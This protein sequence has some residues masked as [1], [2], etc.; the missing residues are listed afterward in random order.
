[1][2]KLEHGHELKEVEPASAAPPEQQ[3]E[4]GSRQQQRGGG[5]GDDLGHEDIVTAGVEVAKAT[6]CGASHIGCAIRS[7]GKAGDK[8]AT[9]S[10]QPNK[11]EQDAFAVVFRH[12]SIVIGIGDK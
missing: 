4:S 6:V 3:R 12:K 8:I 7:K 9:G 5:L 2:P 10:S 1:M 11:A